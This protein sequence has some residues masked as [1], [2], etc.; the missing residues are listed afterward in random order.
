MKTAVYSTRAYDRAFLTEANRSA[1][2][3]H[4]FSFIETHL[5]AQSARMADGHAAICVF[6][7]DVLDRAVLAKLTDNGVRLA[8]LRCAGFNN[9]DVAAAHDAGIALARVPAYSPD[10]IAEHTLALI[11]CLNRKIH[12]AYAR[13]REGNFALEGLLGFDLKG[14]VAGVVGTG[15]IGQRVVAILHGFGCEVIAC[16]PCPSDA[17]ESAGARYV[18]MEELLARSDIVSLHCPLTPQTKHLIDER[19]IAAMKPGVMLINTSRGAVVHAQ[20]LI[21]G[22]KSGRIGHVGLDVYEEEGDL[23]FEDLSG[24][25]LQDDVFARLLTFPN[26]LITGHQGFFTR[27]AMTAIADITIA[28]LSR[29]EETGRPLHPVTMEMVAGR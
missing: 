7:N 28:N 29:F 2:L 17:V 20:A 24:R 16:D 11:L 5:D 27:E 25:V 9:V 8:A 23:F 19:A 15:Q 14:K 12:R 13:V 26:V 22:L 1:G 21:G 3:P 18:D 4:E 6:V 10:A